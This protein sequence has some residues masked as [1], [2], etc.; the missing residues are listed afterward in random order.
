MQPLS[1]TSL[2][3]MCLPVLLLVKNGSCCL[4][5]KQLH[6][7]LMTG[8]VEFVKGDNSCYIVENDNSCCICSGWKELLHMLL[9]SKTVTFVAENGRKWY[10]LGTRSVDMLLKPGAITCVVKDG[11]VCDCCY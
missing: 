2:S 1:V 11:T 9:K 3:N 6:L 10:I 8:E 7:L 4:N 5:W